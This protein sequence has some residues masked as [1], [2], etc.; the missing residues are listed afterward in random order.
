MSSTFFDIEVAFQKQL[1]A[2]TDAPPIDFEGDLPYEPVVLTRY[3]RTNHQP[4]VS[5]QIT[6]DALKRHDGV[7]QVDVICPVNKGMKQMKL[8]Y[9]AIAT[10]F[11]TITS[12]EANNTKLQ[13][14]GATPGKVSRESSYLF[15]FI[16]I[17][18]T[19]Y[20]N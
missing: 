1:K 4:S 13:I 15:G 3:W 19:C 2:M 16:R 7:Y 9:D 14:N 6:A 17:S 8:D 12:L 20:S 5:T 18:Y 10:Q 11:D